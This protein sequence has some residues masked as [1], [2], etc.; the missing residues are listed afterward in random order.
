MNPPDS[1]SN[2]PLRLNRLLKGAGLRSYRLDPKTRMVN[3]ICRTREWALAIRLTPD[4]LNISTLVCELPKEPGV[5][6]R[7]L[8]WVM[9]ANR[10][11]S[12]VKFGISGTCLNLELDYRT[13]HVDETVLANLINLVHTVAE[14][15][16]PRILRIVNGDD[17]LESLGRALE[18][19]PVS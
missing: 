18:Q 9:Q 1:A 17:V 2:D 19:G 3:F 12:L 14:Q 6:A 8:E 10:S 4:W 7:L 5:R 11:C 16:Y 15:Q 13:E